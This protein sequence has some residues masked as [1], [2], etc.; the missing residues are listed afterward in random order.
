[1]QKGKG[2]S[3]GEEDKG[4]VAREICRPTLRLK[5][6]FTMINTMGDNPNYG[7]N[8]LLCTV[9]RTGENYDTYTGN[10]RLPGWYVILEYEFCAFYLVETFHNAVGVPMARGNFMCQ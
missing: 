4:K 7:S 8:L 10:V 3:L 6:S 5:V 9:A 2:G 1:M